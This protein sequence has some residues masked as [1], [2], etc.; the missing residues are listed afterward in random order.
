MNNYGLTFVG[1]S[2]TKM[3]AGELSTHIVTVLLP[4]QSAGL[5]E[6][7]PDELDLISFDE[8]NKFLK[9]FLIFLII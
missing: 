7:Q 1:K 9:V 8:L 2:I 3:N 4:V 5:P 6:S